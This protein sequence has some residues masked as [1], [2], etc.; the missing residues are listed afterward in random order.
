MTFSYYGKISEHYLNQWSYDT[1]RVDPQWAVC[2][3]NSSDLW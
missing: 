2:K 3:I 1:C